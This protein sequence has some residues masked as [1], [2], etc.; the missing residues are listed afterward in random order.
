MVG[1]VGTSFHTPRYPVLIV[2]DSFV[3]EFYPKVH[4]ETGE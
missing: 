1:G 3:R 2:S 4:I